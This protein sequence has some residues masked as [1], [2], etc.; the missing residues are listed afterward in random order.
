MVRKVRR[1]H[2]GFTLIEVLV[3]VAII[4]L[5]VSILLPSLS[6]AKEQARAVV[7]GSSLGHMAKAAAQYGAEQRDWIPGSP[8]TTGYWWVQNHGNKSWDPSLPYFN[9]FVVEWFDFTT[10]LRMQMYGAKSV[11]LLPSADDTRIALF[12]Q[13]TE[14]PFACPSVQ[15]FYAPYQGGT[16]L[17][18]RNPPPIRMTSYLSMETIMRGGP[19]VYQQLNSQGN[20]VAGLVALPPDWE[21]TPPS[22]YVPRVARL[23]RASLKVFAADGMRYYGSETDWDYNCD[24]AASKGIMTAASPAIGW[25]YGREYNQAHNFSYRH[26]NKNRI[27]AGFFDGHVEGLSATVNIDPSVPFTGRAV[28]PQYY[29]PS[30][31]V[32]NEPGELNMSSILRG[33]KM[34]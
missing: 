8:L 7:C 10:P 4:A 3:V 6:R 9:R 15:Q 17:H 5:L 1:E 34:P 28:N 19:G 11:P 13:I 14:E 2:T 32:I 33:T 29:C 22:A 18:G 20:S 24:P 23:G 21:I 30:G 31:S 12:K 25:R 26:G 27:M 16:F